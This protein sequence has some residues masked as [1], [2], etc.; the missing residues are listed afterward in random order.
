V[1]SGGG[2]GEL[3][4]RGIQHATSIGGHETDNKSERLLD[5]NCGAFK[6]GVSNSGT[7]ALNLF[8]IAISSHQEPLFS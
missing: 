5:M 4:G 6:P 1:L 3:L 7:A 2:Q 8:Q